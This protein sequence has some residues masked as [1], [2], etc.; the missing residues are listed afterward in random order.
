MRLK[1]ARNIIRGLAES[2]LLIRLALT[3][4]EY[5]FSNLRVVLIVFNILVSQFPIYQTE[6]KSTWPVS[7]HTRETSLDEIRQFLWQ[8]IMLKDQ[9][10]T[11]LS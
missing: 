6:Q 4:L 2:C 7:S 11:P 1:I 8:P 10:L 3:G 5:I 9:Q